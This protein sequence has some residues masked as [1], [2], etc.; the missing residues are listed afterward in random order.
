[1]SYNQPVAEASLVACL[2]CDLLQR[3]PELEPGASARCPR[4]NKELWRCREDSLNRTLALTL[5]AAVLYVVANSVPG[6]HDARGR[7]V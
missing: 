2:H 4:C 6:V 7:I 1:M 5:A 3:I